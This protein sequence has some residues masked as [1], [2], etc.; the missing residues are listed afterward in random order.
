MESTPPALNGDLDEC[1]EVGDWN[2]IFFLVSIS[3]VELKSN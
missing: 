1:D 3:D 2:M